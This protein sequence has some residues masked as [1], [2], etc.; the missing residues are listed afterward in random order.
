MSAKQ[1][2]MDS[3][4]T[5]DQFFSAC[6]F[7]FVRLFSQIFL[8][9]PKGPPFNFFDILI[10]EWTFKKSQRV[11]PFTFFG[12]MRL[13]GDKKISKKISV[14]FFSFFFHNF[15]IV[16]LLLDEKRFRLYFFWSFAA[17]WVLK[18]TK[19]SPFVFFRICETFFNFFSRKGPPSIFLMI[20]ARRDEKCQSVPLAR[21]S[22]PTFGFLGCF[23]REY[24]DTEVL[25][26]FLSLRYGADMGRSRLVFT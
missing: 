18:N 9:T 15:D 22:G 1:K 24:F 16:R 10:T 17:E 21:Q 12:T 19:R 8:M 4:L 23:R 26:L 11:P 6:N 3:G 2:D 13:T 20:C 14:K 25:L 5:F 7:G